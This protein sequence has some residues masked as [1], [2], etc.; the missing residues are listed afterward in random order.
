MQL[1]PRLRL[2][3]DFCPQGSLL[4]DVGSDHGKLP[5]AL[6][7]EGICP[8]AIATDI[9]AGPVSRAKQTVLRH[10]LA[11]N[12]S[13]RQCDGLTGVRPEEC[14]VV[15]VCGMGGEVMEHILTGSP[16]SF[17]KTLILQPQ[18]KAEVLR[19]CLYRNGVSIVKEVPVLDRGRC[20]SV[21]L[22]GRTQNVPPA[23]DNMPAL[24]LGGIPSAPD[25]QAKRIYLE[26]L[27]FR[28]T[29][30]LHGIRCTGDEEAAARQQR[31]I[32]KVKE[33]IGTCR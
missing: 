27:L 19:A 26:Q 22:A 21:L 1:S 13:V 11:E 28:Q 9:G 5:A 7:A 30:I 18:S 23:P 6:V 31:V 24:L 4:A 10:G 29:Q 17:D 14:T 32:S 8:S 16:W 15:S 2:A 33:V 25:S 12:I 3:A 20:Y